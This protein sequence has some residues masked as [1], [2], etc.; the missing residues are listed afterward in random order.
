[1]SRSSPDDRE[2][3]AQRLR[4]NQRRS[5]QRKK[6]YLASLESQFRDCQRAGIAASVEV[7]TAAK[8]VVRENRS[9]RE[10]LRAR[11]VQ[12]AEIDAWLLRERGAQPA[13]AAAERA[14]A[15]RP[16]TAAALA[17]AQDA[18][19]RK[20]T[21]MVADVPRAPSLRAA[22]SSSPPPLRVAL[23]SSPPP[24]AAAFEPLFMVQNQHHA[25]AFHG[26]ARN[27]Q[28]PQDLYT[29][30]TQVSS[31]PI[32]TPGSYADGFMQHHNT[33]E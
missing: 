13:V 22:L 11:G 20:S 8:R 30:H 17:P 19:R 29:F 9:L 16:C 2:T 31:S 10:L 27:Q 26:L 12:S 7:Q 4:E 18:G 1:M 21:G 6:E 15:K 33:L 25:H 24:T 32:E 5:R 23:S 3:N 14:L 28:A